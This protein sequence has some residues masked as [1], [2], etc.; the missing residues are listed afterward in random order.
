MH[1]FSRNE[2]TPGATPRS[3]YLTCRPLPPL[4]GRLR[5]PR[6]MPPQE[7][8]SIFPLQIMN[9]AVILRAKLA[10]EKEF[11]LCGM[12]SRVSRPIHTREE[13]MAACSLHYPFAAHARATESILLRSPA[14][15]SS[16]AGRNQKIS[17]AVCR[18][19]TTAS[20]TANRPAY[21]LGLR[22][23]QHA[24][25]H[26][27]NGSRSAKSALPVGRSFPGSESNTNPP[28]RKARRPRRRKV[29]DSPQ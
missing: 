23:P 15:S 3:H 27:G 26:A 9:R 16:R 21:T 13:P 8:T 25:P 28:L 19:C 5:V 12:D 11:V 2:S 24:I 17:A 1:S 22:S 29:W 10:E 6:T 18:N 20:R 14:S 7:H 4:Q